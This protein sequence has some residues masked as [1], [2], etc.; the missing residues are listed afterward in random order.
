[1]S[2]EEHWNNW[3]AVK[4]CKKEKRKCK[5]NKTKDANYTKLVKYFDNIV[6]TLFCYTVERQY[7]GYF[8]C[9]IG[10][11]VK[12]SENMA[13]FQ[14]LQ[15]ISKIY[16]NDFLEAAKEVATKQAE[17]FKSALLKF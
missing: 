11:F 2:Y 14:L 4:L 1:M 17:H 8:K 15:P 10:L 13:K 9:E 3:R 6:C 12:A 7:I 16:I 5:F